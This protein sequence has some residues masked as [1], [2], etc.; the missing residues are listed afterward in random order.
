MAFP[1]CINVEAPY[2]FRIAG[3]RQCRFP[4]SPNALFV[5]KKNQTKETSNEINQE[6]CKNLLDNRTIYVYMYICRFLTYLVT[7]AYSVHWFHR[8]EDHS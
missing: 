7:I 1:G 6:V 3:A 8:H 2:A 5:H 4:L